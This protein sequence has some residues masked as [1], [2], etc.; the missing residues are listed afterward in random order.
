ME[1]Y[2]VKTRQKVDIPESRPQEAHSGA[3][4][5]ADR[6]MPLL[7]KKT[8]PNCSDLSPNNSTMP[9]KCLR[10]RVPEE[11]L[12]GGS[13]ERYSFP[14]FADAQGDAPVVPGIRAV[15]TRGQGVGEDTKP[16]WPRRNPLLL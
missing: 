10:S 15:G 1:F 8:A 14:T 16:D 2:N 6:P 11:A 12:C 4:E 13:S 9:C 3:E 5:T 7:G